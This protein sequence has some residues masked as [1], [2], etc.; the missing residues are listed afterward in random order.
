MRNISV[1]LLLLCLLISCKSKKASLSDE[2]SV[3]ISDF[4][5]FFPESTLPVRVADT[6]LNRRSS[7][8][9]LIGYNIFTRFIPDSVLAKDFGKGVKPKLYPLG[10]TQEKGKEIYLFIKA[11][12]AAKKVAYLACFSKDEKFLN[13]MAIVRSGFDRSTM[14][15]GLLDSKFQITTY[16]E[17]RGAGELRFKRNVYIFNSAASDFTLIMTEPNEE[18]IEQVIN[19]I[20]TLARKNKFSG[21]YVKDRRNFVS[22]RD[23]KKANE[24]LFF[25]HFEKNNGECKGELK[26]TIKMTSKT[27]AIYQ[28]PGNPCAIEFSF[29]GASLTIKETGGCGSYR[30]IKCFFEG[31]FPKKTMPKPKP[32]QKRNR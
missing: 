23:T 27:M 9:L 15:Y 31:S 19:P 1:A 24:Y 6:T 14:A 18:I 29:T 11:V 8:S 13:A 12:Y 21:D 2:D 16:R 17:S 28:A 20:D 25:V 7:D 5:E 32:L 22:V 4:I 10:R 30:D 3:E 26:G